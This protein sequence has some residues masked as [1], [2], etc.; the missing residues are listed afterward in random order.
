M[1]P[2]PYS[3]CFRGTIL[4]E[5]PGFRVHVDRVGWRS[6]GGGGLMLKV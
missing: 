2:K 6:V 3:I 5:V 4:Q 1:Y